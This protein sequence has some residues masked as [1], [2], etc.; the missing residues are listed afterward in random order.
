MNGYAPPLDEIRFMLRHIA[1]LDELQ[2]LPGCHAASADVVDQVLEE[3]GRFAASE[4]APINQIGDRTGARLENGV[5]RTP[6][7]FREAY[8]R[9]SEGG[10]PGLP[11]PEAWGGQGLPWTVAVAVGE[12]W[13]AANMAFGL[14]PL[15]TEA[16]AD[17]LLK[18]GSD[19]LK[20]RYLEKLVTGAWT[21]AM[22]LT[23]P[24][25]GTDV[26][27][28]RTRAEPDGDAWRIRGTKIFITY[29]DHDWTENVVHMVLARTPGA[30]DGTRGISLF[31]VPKLLLD[32]NGAPGRRNDLRVVSLEHKLGIHASPTCVV[33]YG[34]SEGA[35]GW[36]IGE[37][38]G[39][40]RA[41]FT[42]MNH[43][44]LAVG[45]EGLAIGERAYQQALA[46]A[47]ERVQG[48]R[49]NGS[50]TTPARIV[51][52]PDV[53]RMLMSMKVRIEAMRALVYATAAATDRSIH[54]ADPEA[55]R[56]AGRRVDLLI[57]L[58]KAWCSDQ[59]FE[60][61]SSALQV[62]GGMGYVEESGAAQHLR[63]ARINMIYEGTNGIQ[64][65]DLVGR[66]LAV[67][68]GRLPWEL[69]DE[70][71]DDLQ[72]LRA[73]DESDL[74]RA[75]E[76]ALEALEASTRWLQQRLQD[77]HDAAL[78]GAAPYLVQFATTLGGFLL[79]RACMAAPAA[80]RV[81]RRRSAMFFARHLLPPAAALTAAVTAGAGLIESDA[82][83]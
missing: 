60:I 45:L 18:L 77:D 40:M 72:A 55:R 5:V 44:R 27:A 42:M 31:L 61:A 74:A 39:G 69:I 79:A 35:L 75:L 24:H 71:K 65:L 6:P 19:P 62:H 78:A 4:L 57:P 50:G 67:E 76:Q 28:L 7:G 49:P 21:G 13:H 80:D 15:L 1:R 37:E 53:R 51:E 46:Y 82:F 58:A 17:A 43:A 63:D 83:S 33:A 14:C 73:D 64:A 52:H 10:W 8:Q 54:A 81:D 56:A 41:M 11:F 59:G 16:A 3:A 66:K 25:A 20:E 26:G 29:G 12:M 36:L 48:R 32:E 2:A 38:H 47:R 30:P 34:E 70:L 68:D 9:F 22:C 23:E